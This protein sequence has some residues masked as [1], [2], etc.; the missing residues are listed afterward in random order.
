MIQVKPSPPLLHFN[1][2]PAP[3]NM[4]PCSIL[5]LDRP[6]CHW[7]LGGLHDAATQF[8]G[9]TPAGGIAIARTICG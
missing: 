8:C 9:G 3:L 1:G 7:P 4:Q 2:T 6:R 5:E